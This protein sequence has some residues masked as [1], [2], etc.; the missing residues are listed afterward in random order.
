MYQGMARP[1]GRLP[2]CILALS[3][4]VVVASLAGC[5]SASPSAGGVKPSTTPLRTP[6][7]SPVCATGSLD[8]AGSSAFFPIAQVAAVTYMHDCPGADISVSDGDSAFG[9]TKVHTAVTSGSPSA[10]STIGMYDGLPSASET[11]GLTG[12]PI[13][14]LIYSI[15]AHTGLFPAGNI[16]TAELRR[17]YAKPG[18]NGILAVGRRAG[19]GTRLTFL[20]TVLGFNPGPPD[21]GNCPQPTGHSFSFT[22]CTEG[23]TSDLL[24]FVNITPGTIGYAQVSGSLAKYP[25][26]SV[27]NIND[28]APTPDNIRNGSYKFW[29]VEH[30]FASTHP[31]ALTKDFLAFLPRYIASSPPND[32][33]PCSDALKKVGADCQ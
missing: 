29:I 6:S 1:K 4:S 30:L 5:S 20:A 14:V 26:V 12:Y 13:G 21:R 15:V 32:F 8:I 24:N 18:E 19:S 23:S 3:V 10:N 16:T 33:V 11:T 31:T 22:S 25:Q 9:L 2:F 7:N 17:I 27:I 28:A